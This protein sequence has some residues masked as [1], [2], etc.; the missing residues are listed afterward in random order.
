MGGWQ[1]EWSGKWVVGRENRSVILL[2]SP[3]IIE[4]LQTIWLHCKQ[5]GSEC[6]LFGTLANN[7]DH[8]ANNIDG[9]AIDM[10]HP[11]SIR[12]RD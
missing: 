4:T 7:I 11:H 5:Y 1:N 9:T 8:M 10:D 2:W 6:N 12:H 3:G